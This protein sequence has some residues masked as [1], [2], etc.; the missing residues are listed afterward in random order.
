M[1][2]DAYQRFMSAAQ[3][4]GM[5]EAQDRRVAP[6]P[7]QTVRHQLVEHVAG[8]VYVFGLAPANALADILS[9]KQSPPPPPA[10]ITPPHEG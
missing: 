1:K 6:R 7:A 3:A 5:V 8:N 2:N 10:F 9:N 4:S